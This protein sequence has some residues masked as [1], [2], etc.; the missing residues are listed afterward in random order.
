MSEVNFS[1]RL[2]E[3]RS[4]RVNAHSLKL[5]GSNKKF[6]E[7]VIDNIPSVQRA[8]DATSLTKMGRKK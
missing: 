3:E 1:V 5:Y 7:A 8:L 6:V 4:R 2:S